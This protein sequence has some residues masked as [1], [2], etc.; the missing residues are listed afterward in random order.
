[1]H[2]YTSQMSVKIY[3]LILDRDTLKLFLCSEKKIFVEVQTNCPF[4][5]AK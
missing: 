1:M 5:T 4:C 3:C 2:T